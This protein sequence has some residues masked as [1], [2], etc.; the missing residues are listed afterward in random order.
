MLE[1]LVGEQHP[2]T[3]KSFLKFS[4]TS[5]PLPHAAG[6]G[7]RKQRGERPQRKGRRPRSNCWSR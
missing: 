1:A 6:C 2:L 3:R 7:S 4:A 5:A